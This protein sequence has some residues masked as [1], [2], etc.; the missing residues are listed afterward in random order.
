MRSACLFYK[1]TGTEKLIHTALEWEEIEGKQHKACFLPH[2]VLVFRL[3]LSLFS[4]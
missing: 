4:V 2:L 3:K 1:E